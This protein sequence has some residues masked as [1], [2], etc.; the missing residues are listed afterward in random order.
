MKNMIHM[1]NFPISEDILLIKRQLLAVPKD[2]FGRNSIPVNNAC[3]NVVDI[4][5]FIS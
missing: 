3:I 1:A 4:N 5:Q 2:E